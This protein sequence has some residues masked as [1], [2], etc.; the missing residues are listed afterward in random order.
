MTILIGTRLIGRGLGDTYE[1]KPLLDDE[2]ANAQKQDKKND[3]TKPKTPP[4]P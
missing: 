1:L 4:P 2:K 3:F